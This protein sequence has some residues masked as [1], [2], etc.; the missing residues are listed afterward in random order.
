MG[1]E[2]RRTRPRGI[3]SERSSTAVKSPNRL[4]TRSIRTSASG[5]LS[6]RKPCRVAV[7]LRSIRTGARDLSTESAQCS[8]VRRAGS[9]GARSSAPTWRSPRRPRPPRPS[10][11]HRRPSDTGPAHREPVAARPRRWRR[12]RREGGRAAP[13]PIPRDGLPAATGPR[14][15]ARPSRL[16]GQPACLR[17]AA[18]PQ[19]LGP[20]LVPGER[21]A[22]AG[23]LEAEGVLAPGADLADDAPRRATPSSKRSRM[24]AASSELIVTV[25]VSPVGGLEGGGRLG[26]RAAA[27]WA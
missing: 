16:T 8:A 18:D 13:R 26:Q 27:G 17:A 1:R 19:A 4:V 7:G 25:S 11:R 9:L 2:G 12:R 10:G 5:T 21:S 24:V 15:V 3:S 20:L 6:T 22:R 23:D 14:L